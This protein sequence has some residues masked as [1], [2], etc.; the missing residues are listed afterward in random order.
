MIEKKESGLNLITL[1]EIDLI[2]SVDLPPLEKHYL[3]LL[4][5]CLVSFQLM[6]NGSKK[7]ALPSDDIRIKW[8]QS[9]EELT[10]EPSF[11]D[12]LL[13]QFKTVA[14]E[15]ES[16]AMKQKVSPLE[17]TLEDL[18]KSSLDSFQY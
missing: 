12:L 9:R 10:C 15:L 13:E 6:A 11:L 16:I 4:A 18:I 8:L 1:E 5:H 7:G 3:R 2:E 14:E 17:L